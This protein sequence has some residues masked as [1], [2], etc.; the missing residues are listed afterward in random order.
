MRHFFLETSPAQKPT[1]GEIVV[2]DQEES[3]HLGTVLRGG[4]KTEVTLT[5]GRGH[6]FNARIVS[7]DRREAS[8]EILSVMRDEGEFAE[9]RLVLGL[10]LVK[11]KRFEW[12]LEKAVELGVHRIVP[13]VTEHVGKVSGSN[14][15]K[16]WQTIMRSAIK[17]CGR[18]LLPELDEPTPVRE[19]LS[20]LPVGLTVFGTIPEE[21][22]S[23]HH[24]ASLLELAQGHPPVKPAH[25]TAL[26]GPEGGWTAAEV[27]SFLESN[28]QPITLGPHILRAETAATACVAGL[29]GVR[30]AWLSDRSGT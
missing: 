12:A 18:S 1:V 28:L 5:D 29:Q 25:L 10:A 17:Q 3:H 21:L 16:R 22:D 19:F 24:C 20:Q 23:E 8:L 11:P 4:R 7:Q 9:P 30:Q 27:A 26:I 6:R 14:K 15:S 2:L 13:L